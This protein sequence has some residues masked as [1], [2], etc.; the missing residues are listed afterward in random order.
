MFTAQGR[1][2]TSFGVDAAKYAAYP[3]QDRG[4]ITLGFNFNDYGNGL[5]A[6]SYNKRKSRVK[7]LSF[8]F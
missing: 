3:N 7:F 8:E 2:Q 4:S 6:V 5:D 1:R